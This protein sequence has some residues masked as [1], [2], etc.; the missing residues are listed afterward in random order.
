MNDS[1]R[2]WAGYILRKAQDRGW[3]PRS[4]SL[5]TLDR[6]RYFSWQCTGAPPEGREEWIHES[7]LTALTSEDR[8]IALRAL[9][10]AKGLLERMAEAQQGHFIHDAIRTAQTRVERFLGVS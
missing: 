10:T 9:L 1:E 6:Q 3:A 8:K 5:A 4:L 7:T 2:Y